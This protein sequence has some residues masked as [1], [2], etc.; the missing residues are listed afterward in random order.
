MRTLPCLA[1]SNHSKRGLQSVRCRSHFLTQSGRFS[2]TSVALPKHLDTNAQKAKHST[3]QLPRTPK[4]KKTAPAKHQS[5]AEA[6][7]YY[8]ARRRDLAEDGSHV[9]SAVERGT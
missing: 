6:F 8:R 9:T 5:E 1:S 4:Q 2:T 7:H 3:H